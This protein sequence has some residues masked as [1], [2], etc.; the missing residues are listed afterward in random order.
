MLKSVLSIHGQFPRLAVSAW[1]R[2]GEIVPGTLNERAGRLP[3]GPLGQRRF[4][5]GRGKGSGSSSRDEG[6]CPGKPLP[7]LSLVAPFG[8]LYQKLLP[9]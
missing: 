8:S 1:C 2:K 7:R 3:T 4:R 9:G 5:E 6:A